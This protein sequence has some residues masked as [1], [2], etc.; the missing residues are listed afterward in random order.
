MWILIILFAELVLSNQVSMIDHVSRCNEQCE[1]LGISGSTHIFTGDNDY[2]VCHCLRSFYLIKVAENITENLFQD[3]FCTEASEQCGC[4]SLNYDTCSEC[5]RSNF[6]ECVYNIKIGTHTYMLL[7]REKTHREKTNY[8]HIACARG[9]A[10]VDCLI[11]KTPVC[12][13]SNKYAECKCS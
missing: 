8:A 1:K 10:S 4:L 12:M 2:Y 11:D 5:I 13:C 9:F 6:T 7:Y 3:D